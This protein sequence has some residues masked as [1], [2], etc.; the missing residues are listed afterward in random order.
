MQSLY[1]DVRYTLQIIRRSPGFVVALMVILALAVGANTAIFSVVYGIVFRP[2]PFTNPNQLYT[3]FSRQA[4]QNLTRIYASGPDFEDFKR[5]NHSFAQIAEVLPYFS[6]TLVGKGDPQILRCTA[7]SPEFFPMLG[8]R[9]L[10]GRLYRPNE[11][12]SNESA[13]II[14]YKLWRRLY[15]G[16]PHIIGKTM[17]LGGNIGVI[18]GVMPPLPDLYPET[19]VWATLIP[20]FRFMKWRGNRFMDI[21]GR[22]K[23]GVAPHQAEQELTAILHRAPETPPGMEEYLVPLKTELIGNAKQILAVL[24]S[25]AG[26]L[27]LIACVNIA[28]LLLARSESRRQEIAVR[29]SLGASRNRLLRQL[30][31][32][33]LVLAFMG[34]GVGVLLASYATDLIVA[35]GSSQ[36][37]R[38]SEIH[39]NIYV[40]AFSLLAVCLTSLLFGL[41][42]ASALLRTDLNS[43]L[44][45]GRGH[46]G[47]WSQ[48]RRKFL[49]IAEVS[50]SV[51]LLMGAGLMK[52]SLTNL[53]RLD[54]GF[55][56]QH[57][58]MV[59]M[60]LTDRFDLAHQLNFYGR[61][62]TEVPQTPGVKAV[63]VADCIPGIRAEIAKLEMADRIL[64]PNHIPSASGCWIGGDYFQAT[65]TPLLSG[66]FFDGRD[67]A[68]APLVAIINRSLARRYWSNEDPIG[69]R[70]SVSYTGPGR[71]TDNR[72]RWRQI[73][74]VVGDVKQHGLDE[75]PDPA[76]YLPFYQDE[77]HHVYVSM[78]VFVRESS[79]SGNLAGTIR[80][81]LRR[82]EPGLPAPVQPMTDVLSNWIGTRHFT[83][84]LLTSFATLATLLAGFGIYGVISYAVARRTKEIGVRIALGADRRD[85]ILMVLREVLVPVAMG[86]LAGGFAG[87]GGS[88]LM[89]GVLY[90]T[91][92]ADPAVLLFT[93]LLMLLIA[94]AAAS[95]PAYRAA[96]TDPV[97]ALRGE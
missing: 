59:H 9:P 60:R 6:E 15:G 55:Q 17:D 81:R 89:G 46:A 79:E 76:V 21:I 33:N 82:I 3:V 24:M 49:I 28:T 66:R 23:P 54:L 38:S 84:V 57:L 42:P 73:V 41:T 68:A 25:A 90:R 8:V 39:I 48:S 63:G 71:T 4:N 94:L 32:E 20:D 85:T 40:L 96:S 7:I 78:N 30:F 27:L 74:G 29:I 11:Y 31:T 70:I 37:P 45:L 95:V 10:L 87:V 50:L 53:M 26:L 77:T 69:K 43:V 67:N 97:G 93:I 75:N 16:D 12:H 22:L 61:V 13:T 64:D 51:V 56:P 86:V 83:L 47:M 14:S 52:R 62:L 88:R 19:D 34:G 80:S 18:V 5:Q 2:L 36:L 58:F 91:S 92:A 1:Q 72:I 44:R 65:G 35:A